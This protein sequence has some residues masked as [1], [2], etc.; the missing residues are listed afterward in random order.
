MND[1]AHPREIFARTPVHGPAYSPTFKALATLIV[2]AIVYT[3][4]HA[5]EHHA[6]RV[7]LE[8]RAGFAIVGASLVLSYWSLLRSTTT[9]DGHG[10][11]QSAMLKAP[12][13]WDDLR[14]ARLLRS[15]GA[16][17]LIVRTDAGRVSVFHAGNDDVA[18]AFA[19]I[20]RRYPPT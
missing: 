18:S 10:I 12:V 8:V 11:T 17:R 7:G 13:A 3:G 4:A 1:K 2:M 6:I 15:P 14:G 16:V 20:A 19:L 5:L 9:I